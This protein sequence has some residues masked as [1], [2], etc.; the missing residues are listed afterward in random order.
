M[1]RRILC[2]CVLL[3]LDL[4]I[5]HAL[6][7]RTEGCDVVGLHNVAERGEQI[8]VR[9]PRHVIVHVHRHQFGLEDL[10]HVI[11]CAAISARSQAGFRA[12]HDADPI[13]ALEHPRR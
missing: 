1:R 11:R 6:K 4:L 5:G 3:A 8:R 10:G 13:F 9:D 12:V 7:A 2:C